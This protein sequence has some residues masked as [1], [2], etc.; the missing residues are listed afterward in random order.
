LT[1]DL[2]R[3]TRAQEG[4][5]GFATALA[6]IESGRKR[7]HWIWYIFPQLAGLGQSSASIHYG[8]QGADEAAAYLRNRVLRDRLLRVTDA[9]LAQLRRNPEVTLVDVMGSEIDAV[10]LISSMTL[11]REIARRIDDRDLAARA[12]A[13]LQAAASQGYRECEFTLR[14]LARQA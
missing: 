2:D 5:G 13:I 7:S 6:E 1:F 12:D 10:K 9:V 3:F 11:F 8:L 4:P 14:E